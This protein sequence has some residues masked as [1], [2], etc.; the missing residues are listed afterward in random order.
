MGAALPILKTD[1]ERLTEVKKLSDHAPGL[2]PALM[3]LVQAAAEM[4]LAEANEPA[5]GRGAKKK[6]K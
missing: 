5:K 6:K 3:E 1:T 2:D 4:E